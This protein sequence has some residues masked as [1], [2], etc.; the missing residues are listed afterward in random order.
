[1]GLGYHHKNS[2]F[3]R[4]IQTLKLGYITLILHAGIYWLEEITTML[5]P[6]AL[7]D[8]SQQLNELKVDNDGI[9]IM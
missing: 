9:N 3:E 5:C 8:F 7:N 6:Y 4:N 2:I 1:M